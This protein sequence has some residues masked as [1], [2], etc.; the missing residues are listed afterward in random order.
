[1]RDAIVSLPQD[2]KAILRIVEDPD[3][4]DDHRTLAAGALLHVLSGH[5]AIPG[6]RGMLAYVDDVIILRLTLE[7]LLRLAP[8]VMTQQREDSPELF[9]PLAEQMDAVRAYLGDLLGVLEKACEGLPELSHQGHSAA[10][11]AED[12]E[13]AMW[14]YDAVQQAIIDDLDIEEDDVTRALRDVSQIRRPLEQ[15]LESS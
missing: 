8:D 6:M 15:R 5:N 9:E 12:A 1:M 11:C 14:L 3:L 4:E 7:Q 10:A 13:A 2:M